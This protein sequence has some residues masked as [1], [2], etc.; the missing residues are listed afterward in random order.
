MDK[1]IIIKDYD[2]NW[3]LKFEEEKNTLKAIMKEKA[4]AIEHIGS[5][6]IKGLGAKEIIDIMV[7]VQHLKDVEEFIEPLKDIGYEHVSHAQFPNRRFFRKGLWRAGTHHLHVY[8]Y[9]SKEWSSNLLF[10]DYLRTHPLILQEY[11]Q[12]K[13]DLA[14]KHH[15]D[16]AAY[17]EAKA[18]FIID[19]IKKAENDKNN[20]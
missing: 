1:P 20:L 4:V 9:G 17:T 18:P 13:R 12:L 14:E 3:V 15:F 7:G 2:A 10:R 6:S 11:Q 16:R 8:E 5:T 19:T